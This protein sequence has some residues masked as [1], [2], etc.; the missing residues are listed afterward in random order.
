MER[1][2]KR[3]QEAARGTPGGQNSRCRRTPGT[4]TGQRVHPGEEGADGFEVVAHV[5]VVDVS[6]QARHTFTLAQDV[7]VQ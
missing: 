6:K 3:G 2:T 1:I 4:S 5:G 7:P